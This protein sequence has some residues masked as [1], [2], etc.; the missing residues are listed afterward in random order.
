MRPIA[1]GLMAILA[2]GVGACGDD[3]GGSGGGTGLQTVRIPAVPLT[4]M[5]PVYVARE[6]GFFREEGIEL[7]LVSGAEDSPVGV[8]LVM[9]GKADLALNGPTGTLQAAQQGMPLRTV[10]GLTRIG[11][12]EKQ[13]DSAIVVKASSGIDGLEDLTGKA[14]ALTTLKGAPEWTVRAAIDKAGG[15]SKDVKFVQ[16]PL[17]ALQGLVESGK[18]DA[19][20]IPDPV[21]PRALAGGKLKQIARHSH[22]V[23]PGAPSLLFFGKRDWV[24]KHQQAVEGF[25]AALERAD[26]FI[27]DPANRE[28]LYEILGRET[29]IPAQVLRKVHLND[30]DVELTPADFTSSLAFMRRYGGPQKDVDVRALLPPG[31]EN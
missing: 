24:D 9:S 1:A 7:K 13:D 18:V 22:L 25:R 2:L 14:V 16:S 17:P 21:L 15:G 30:F 20:A 10:A 11:R 4:S 19:A 27:A 28:R 3:K 31:S 26:A 5:L 8:P 23:R 6:K 12:T 29:K